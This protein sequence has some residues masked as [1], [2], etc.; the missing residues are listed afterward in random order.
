M[1]NSDDF[2]KR[3]VQI[4]ERHDLNASSF[5][6]LVGVGRSSISH[7]LS[8]RNKPSLDFVLSVLKQFSDVDLY[9][10]LNGKGTYPK[11]I[12]ESDQK[13][14]VSS[15]KQPKPNPIFQS[16]QESI[17]PVPEHIPNAQDIDSKL[18]ATSP[19]KKGKNITKVILFYEDGTFESF[20]R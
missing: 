16:E 3:L 7:L 8:G 9:W 4:M 14:S 12:V 6:D 11:T 15:S 2:S 1:V 20:D 19:N 10:F 17:K 13:T 5:A 18:T